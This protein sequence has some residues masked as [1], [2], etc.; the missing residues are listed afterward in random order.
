[1]FVVYVVTLYVLWLDP[2][3]L[4]TGSFHLFTTSHRK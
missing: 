4:T 2:F 3:T 1:V